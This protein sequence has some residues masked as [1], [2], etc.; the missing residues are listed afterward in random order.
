[1]HDVRKRIIILSSYLLTY[2]FCIYYIPVLSFYWWQWLL[3]AV[4][5]IPTSVLSINNTDVTYLWV[6]RWHSQCPSEAFYRLS[7]V[8]FDPPKVSYLI[9]ELHWFGFLPLSFF[10]SFLQNV[11]IWRSHTIFLRLLLCKYKGNLQKELW[12]FLL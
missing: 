6:I 2:F 7:C 10:Q 5:P 9:V 1:M 11:Y 3:V 12:L 4:Y 8:S